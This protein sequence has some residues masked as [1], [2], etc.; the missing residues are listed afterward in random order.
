MAFDI[1]SA[2]KNTSFDIASAKPSTT[3][4]VPQVNEGPGWFQPGSRS[5]A[6]VRGFS[7]AATFGFGDEAQAFLRSLSGQGSY[8]DLR[9][10]ER[11]AN[12]AAATGPHSGYNLAGNV[13]GAIPQGLQAVRSGIL[14]GPGL[15]KNA[16]GAGKAGAAMGAVQGA[17]ATEDITNLPQV[18]KDVGANATLGAASNAVAVPA[19]AAITKFG[20]PIAQYLKGAATDKTA[21]ATAQA[22]KDTP[23]VAAPVVQSAGAALANKLSLPAVGAVLNAGRVNIGDNKPDWSTDPWSAAG[24]T[25]IAAG[26]GALA[27]AGL[28][29]GTRL[30]GNL[31][32]DAY[33]GIKPIAQAAGKTLSQTAENFVQSGTAGGETFASDS[34]ARKLLNSPFGTLKGYLQTGKASPNASVKQ[35]AQQ[36]EQTVANAGGDATASRQAAMAAQ[37]TP[38]GRAVTNSDSV[39]HEIEHE[40]GPESLDEYFKKLRTMGD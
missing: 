34:A 11:A 36:I 19:A 20:K 37:G 21:A 28:K 16:L 2:K 31:A 17:G 13:V 22:L 9:D 26:T 6:A 38:E 40:S 23:V 27:G 32:T 3:N 12:E 15:I 1:N 8:K 35:A 29:Y 18:I 4:V 33:Q 10:Q 30:A 5:D 39:V 25:A 7:N 24:E 14:Q